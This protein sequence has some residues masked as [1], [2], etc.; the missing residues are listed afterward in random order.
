METM[1][2]LWKLN[3]L[4]C[5]G[6]GNILIVVIG[7]C[8][9]LCVVTKYD[10]KK[11]RKQRQEDRKILKRYESSDKRMPLNN[12]EYFKPSEKRIKL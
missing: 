6:M 9:V 5:D 11:N 7:F 4:S 3:P 12:N 8:L 10:V 2:M 1:E